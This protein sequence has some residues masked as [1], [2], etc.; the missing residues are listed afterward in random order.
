MVG[1]Q[2]VPGRGGLVPGRG[3]VA[4]LG[5]GGPTS[6]TAPVSFGGTT[7]A[8]TDLPRRS[9][10][11]GRRSSVFVAEAVAP[12]R[13]LRMET[14]HLIEQATAWRAYEDAVVLVEVFRSVAPESR[15]R[16]RVGPWK[17]R[18]AVTRLATS[19]PRRR[20][21]VV[22]VADDLR[23]GGVRGTGG[24]ADREAPL[25]WSYL[26][27]VVRTHAERLVPDPTVW[28]GELT[29][30][31]VG[32]F[33]RSQGIHALRLSADRA[34][35]VTATRELAPIPG[36]GVEAHVAQM[37]RMPWLVEQVG[38]DLGDVTERVGIGRRKA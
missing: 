22:Q 37:A 28:L 36:A 10:R 5:E 7:I 9:Q 2:L 20:R 13:A 33:P 12:G 25:A 6:S 35:V 18:R 14:G 38:L 27:A 26:P 8:W 16:R 29:Q 31:A 32:G 34:V 15:G 17:H 30:Q 21:G 4:V 24:T 1:R 11:E 19:P 3:T 23:V